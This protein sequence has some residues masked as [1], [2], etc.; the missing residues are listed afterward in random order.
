MKYLLLAVIFFAAYAFW[1]RSRSDSFSGGVS[2]KPNQPQQTQQMLACLHCG[3]H[4]P[5][6]EAVRGRLGA[7]C[8][9]AHCRL[10]GDQPQ[11]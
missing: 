1:K 7:Y 11:G 5:E 6:Q 10:S 2:S 9:D 4:M 3:V 8:S